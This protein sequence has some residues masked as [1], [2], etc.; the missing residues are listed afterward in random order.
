MADADMADEEELRF[1]PRVPPGPDPARE[2]ARLREHR[3]VARVRL[4]D[5]R[6]AWLASSYADNHRLLADARLS[7]AAAARE[8]APRVRGI[9]LEAGSITTMDPPEHTRLRRLI[10]G[11]FTAHRMRRFRPRIRAIAEEL[12]DAMAAAGPPADLVAGFAGPLPIRV[13]SAL[14][15]VPE[16]DHDR[17][18][19]WADDY[20]GTTGTDPG[21]VLRAAERLR[22]YFAALV[23]ARRT[24]PG[25][26]LL[27]SLV[28][29]RDEDRLTER[30]L[31][32]LGVTLL[33]AGYQTA[34][35]LIAGSVQTLLDH[36]AQLAGLRGDPGLMPAAAEELL[37]YVAVSA[38]GGTIRVATRDL[39]LGGTRIRAGEAVLPAITSANRDTAVFTDPDRLDLRRAPNPH[40]AFGHGVHRCLG[41]ALARAELAVAL[42]T[43][44]ERFPGLRYAEPGRRPEW[45]TG[46][47]I[48]GPLA[49]P[50]AW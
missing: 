43:L 37:R 1:P 29:A 33:V 44:L 42:S 7:R 41:A 26:D 48:R 47:M 12:A 14:L 18:R 24:D 50:V 31:V 30:E 28:T 27:S 23:A 21:T 17:F 34:A 5:G 38:G 35:G 8:G 9:A 6:P 15:G 46:G 4:P 11:E 10:A 20:L 3:P 45:R 49:L 2:Y 19:G 32:A 16:P 39:E 13:I 40:L 25:D 22:A 36:P